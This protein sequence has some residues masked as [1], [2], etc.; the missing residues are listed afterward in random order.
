MQGHHRA[1]GSLNRIDSGL[2]IVGVQTATDY[3]RTFPRER[4]RGFTPHAP[5][6]SRDDAHLSR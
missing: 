1:A 6:R 2:R 5:A 3:E 4:Q